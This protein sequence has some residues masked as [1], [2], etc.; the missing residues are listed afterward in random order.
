MSPRVF[1]LIL[2]R[3][4][5]SLVISLSLFGQQT[6]AAGPALI[7]MVRVEGGTFQRGSD[8]GEPDEAPVHQV[9]LSGFWIGTHEVTQAQY[10]AI[11]G[12]NPSNQ[13]HGIGPNHPVTEV[14]WVDAIK[15]CNALSVRE[16]LTPVY[17][18]SGSA[19]TADWSANGYRL[20]TEAE[21]EFAARGGLQSRDHLYAGGDKI[22]DV[23]WYRQN[24]NESAQPV[25]AKVPNELGLHDMS[26]NVWE[27]V[28]DYYGPY[29]NA[30]KTDP[31]GPNT[32]SR[33]VSRGGSWVYD[34]NRGRSTNRS[35]EGRHAPAPAARDLGFRV[36][37]NAL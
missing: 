36:A 26:G 37:R 9:T 13:S 11:T 1:R 8:N 15:F 24:S 10:Q 31:R 6:V 34:P 14:S 19:V 30:P 7:E 22:N 21:W 23:G 35:A 32:G 25:G 16:G 33:R 28:W 4:A 17:T 3:I 5:A 27:W 18:L 20:P 12:E 29:T 2:T